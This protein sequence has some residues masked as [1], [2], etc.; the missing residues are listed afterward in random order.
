[1]KEITMSKK[2][3]E[4]GFNLDQMKRIYAD[5]ISQ[6]GRRDPNNFLQRDGIDA[7]NRGDYPFPSVRDAPCHMAL[8]T[9]ELTNGGKCFL[10]LRGEADRDVAGRHLEEL[11]DWLTGSPELMNEVRKTN[12]TWP[13]KEESPDFCALFEVR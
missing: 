3:Q 11:A 13:G 10:M 1:M 8:K 9:I 7:S 5:S 12:P 2:S 4:L 6:Y